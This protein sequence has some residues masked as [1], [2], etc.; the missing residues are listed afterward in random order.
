MYE[1]HKKKCNEYTSYLGGL[2]YCKKC[3]AKYAKGTGSTRKKGVYNY[4]YGCYSRSK[5][6]PKMVKDPNCKNKNWKMHDLDNIIIEEIKKLVVDPEY[7]HVIK[8]AK[9]EKSDTPNKIDILKKE[10][11]K[12]DDQISRFMD[13][14]GIGKFTIDQVSNKIDPLNE[15]MKTLEKELEGLNATTDTMSREE[16][17]EIASTF[18]EA[19][20][21]GD[22]N[23][24][25]L[26]IETLISYIEIDNDDVF[27][28]WRFC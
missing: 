21:G 1:Q 27:I 26:V 5:R 23:E 6:V 8:N 13:L 15:Q 16:M 11:A 9:D 3:G 25:R 4:Y 7:F 10:I 14:Y 18:A 28:H 24:I 20:E 17:L 12:L 22:I 2:V 19:L